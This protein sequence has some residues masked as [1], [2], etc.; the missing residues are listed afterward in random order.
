[1]ANDPVCGNEVDEQNPPGGK[2]QYWGQHF[3]FCG[4]GCRAAFQRE[5][6]AYAEAPEE[7]NAEPGYDP[8][9]FLGDM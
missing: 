4:R 8:R 1:M 7:E 9:M 2:A 3:Y 6:H 5:P